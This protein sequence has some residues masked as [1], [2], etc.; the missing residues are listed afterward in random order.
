VGV[1]GGESGR[2]Y[3]VAKLEEIEE[4]SD[5]RSPSRPIRYHFGI[6]SFGINSFTGNEA[7]DRIINEHDEAEADEGQEELYFVHCG[8]ARFEFD[9]DSVEADAGTF[10]FVPRGVKRTAFGEEPGTTVLVVGGS[11]GT[12]YVP[13]GYEFWAPLVPLYEA[14]KYAEAADRGQEIL[15]A[16]PEYPTPLYNVACCESLA[17]RKAEA[18]EH[19]RLAIERSPALRSLAAEDTDFDPIRDDPEFQELLGSAHS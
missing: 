11:P 10:V 4:I 15:E 6:T 1:G 3:R 17:G 18:I 8:R 5:G 13:T 7:G 2:R 16:H 9:G 19:L 14:G 12:A